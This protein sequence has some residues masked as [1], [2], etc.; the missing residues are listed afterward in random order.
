ML[1]FT[2]DQFFDFSSSLEIV[3]FKSPVRSALFTAILADMVSLV[4]GMRSHLSRLALSLS[5]VCFALSL[6]APRA[7]G[8][9][10]F[11]GKSVSSDNS[12]LNQQKQAHGLVRGVHERNFLVGEVAAV[13]EH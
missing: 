4:C 6:K 12:N 5:T 13:E 10:P 11:V 8:S 7:H 1:F 9:M 3:K 2:D